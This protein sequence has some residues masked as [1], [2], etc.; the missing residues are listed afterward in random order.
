MLFNLKKKALAKPVVFAVKQLSVCLCSAAVFSRCYFLLLLLA[1]VKRESYISFNMSVPF[2]ICLAGK[3][4]ESWFGPP[5]GS[6]IV[7]GSYFY[8]NLVLLNS[9]SKFISKIFI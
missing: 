7:L 9:Y 5:G 2:D 6:H 3:V 1:Y 8:L 4:L